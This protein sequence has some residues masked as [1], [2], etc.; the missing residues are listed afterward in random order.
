M[1]LIE[2][3]EEY[4]KVVQTWKE[5]PFDDLHQTSELMKDMSIIKDSL[6]KHK[7]D[8]KKQWSA[9][10]FYYFKS[11]E[12]GGLGMSNA[13]A[14]KLATHN[15]PEVDQIRYII[16]SGSDMLG[17]MRSQVSVLKQN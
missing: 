16:N 12:K 10:W 6:V 15:V 8:Y 17:V 3:L 1:N 9:K 4:N 14:E 7:I 13:A 2:V 11:K 5:T